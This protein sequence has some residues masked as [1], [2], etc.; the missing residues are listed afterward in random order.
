MAEMERQKVVYKLS[1]HVVPENVEW[2]A[3]VYELAYY[4]GVPLILSYAKSLI[5]DKESI[6][7]IE[8]FRRVRNVDVYR[9]KSANDGFCLGVP[10][11]G[12]MD[13]WQRFRNMKDKTLGTIFSRFW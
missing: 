11:S 1:F 10:K 3:D 8:R 6:R 7:Y 4:K 9:V 12:L 13:P 2:L 5:T